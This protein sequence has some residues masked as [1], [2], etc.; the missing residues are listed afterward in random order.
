MTLA[1]A[2]GGVSPDPAPR[3]WVDLGAVGVFFV[4]LSSIVTFGSAA[5]TQT[6]MFHKINT[7]IKSMMLRSSEEV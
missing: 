2:W 1:S 3:T 5:R 6:Y 4:L 7:W